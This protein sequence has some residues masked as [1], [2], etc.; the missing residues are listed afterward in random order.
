[1]ITILSD[2]NIEGQTE[3]LWGTLG[4]EGWL[5]LISLEWVTFQDVGLPI[6]SNDREVWRFAQANNLILLTTNRSM[7]DENSLE[8]TMREENTTTSLPVLTIGNQER[9]LYDTV[10]R[11]QCAERL[12]DVLIDLE[13]Y[14]GTR[15]VFIP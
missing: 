5:S 10:Y 2:H 8:Q 6:D 1:V 3:L 14:L 15:R 4:S 9:I 11:Q 12:V 13:N 7:K